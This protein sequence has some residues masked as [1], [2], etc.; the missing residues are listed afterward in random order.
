MEN[1]LK[2]GQIPEWIVDVPPEK[3]DQA[4]QTWKDNIKRRAQKVAAIRKQKDADKEIVHRLLKSEGFDLTYM[5]C[6]GYE[7][8]IAYK[9]VDMGMLCYFA[10]CSLT[11]EFSKREARKLL[12]ERVVQK[13]SDHCFPCTSLVVAGD[14]PDLDNAAAM[15]AFM[16][17]NRFVE[18]VMCNAK[19]L[20]H[21]MV[22]EMREDIDLNKYRPWPRFLSGLEI[23]HMPSENLPDSIT[24]SGWSR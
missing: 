12:L 13:D 14:N 23:A 6:Y 20:P 9:D 2:E 1:E 22:R 4:T 5:N 16:I 11:D 18:Y 3:K 8:A 21:D 7:V 10:T 19:G 24:T 17:R 15:F